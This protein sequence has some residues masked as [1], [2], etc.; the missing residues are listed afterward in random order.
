[1]KETFPTYI[2]KYESDIRI[3]DLFCAGFYGE[4]TTLKV[5]ELCKTYTGIDIDNE[6]II[7]MQDIYKNK[8]NKA[9]FITNDVYEYLRAGN[10]QY[11]IVI[12]DQPTNQNNRIIEELPLISKMA[13]KYMVISTNIQTIPQMPRGINK[14]YLQSFWYRSEYLGGTYWAVYFVDGM[15]D[16][17]R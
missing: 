3:L 12:S 13:I 9:R 11:E 5:I 15:L 16:G 4:N 8:Y 14:F 7:T 6:K 2:L 1:M 17:R 10:E